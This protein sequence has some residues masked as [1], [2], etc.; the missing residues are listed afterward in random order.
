MKS[1]EIYK[2]LQK[3]LDLWVPWR[4]KYLHISG[5]TIQIRHKG[6]TIFNSAFGYKNLKRKEK[7]TTESLFRVASISKMFT[8]VSI[9]Q[10]VDQEK[11]SL[12]SKI[13]KYLTEF[14]DKDLK[15]ITVRNLLSHQGGVFRDS[16]KNYWGEN[17]FTDAVLNDV[18]NKTR[19][20]PQLKHFK[21]SNFGFSVLGK[22]IEKISGLSYNEHVVEWIIKKLKLKNTYPDY[23]KELKDRL[24]LGYSRQTSDETRHIFKHSQTLEYSPAT[25]FISNTTDLSIFLNDILGENSKLLPEYLQKEMSHPYSK[26]EESIYYGL[27]LE[28]SDSGDK[29]VIGHS[30]GYPGFTS[31][32]FSVPEENLSA[33]VL[34][35]SRGGPAW[36]ITSS[37]FKLFNWLKDIET[38]KGKIDTSIYEGVYQESWGESCIIG[39]G[40]NLIAVD[41]EQNV[42]PGLKTYLKPVKR[43]EF[44]IKTKD[45]F[46][47]PEETVI[48][49]D[50][51]NDKAQTM[52]WA[53][54]ISKRIQ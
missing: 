13:S 18:S 34:T 6:K 7:M 31:S 10:L 41:T 25:G 30:G 43:D 45:Y 53:G 52:V 49:K 15:N 24:S 40:S 51:K 22:V 44:V 17:K 9:L 26:A 38:H 2:T 37:V 3:T 27:G 47:S 48:F 21:Y 54:G 4:M 39:A 33:V 20:M 1:P 36:N 42:L 35:N 8:A 14:R 11:I 19:V 29:K 23:T 28:I 5:I 12:E 16:N 50:F 32:A 46:G